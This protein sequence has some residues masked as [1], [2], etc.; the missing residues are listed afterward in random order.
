MKTDIQIAQENVMEPIERI[1]R[2]AK[3]DSEYLEHYGKYKAKIDLRIMEGLNNQKDGKLILVT[4]INPTK[5]GEGKSTTTVGLADGLARLNKMV[6]GALREPSLGPVFGVKGG[7][8]GGGMAQVVPME[9]INLHFNGDMH[10]VTTANNLIS[11]AIDNHMYHGNTLNIDP[12]HIVWKRCMDMN[13]RA[14]RQVRVAMGDKNGIERKD[15][16]NITVASEIMAILCLSSSLQDFQQRVERCVVAYNKDNKPVTVKDLSVGGAVAMIMKEAI[17]PNLVQTLEKTPILIHGGPFANIA[18]GCNSI[19]ATKMALKLADYVVTES[20]FGVDLGAEKFMDIKCQVAKIVPNAIVVVATI[21]ALKLHGG[22]AYELL[23]EENIDA[24]ANGVENMAKHLETIKK[25]RVPY[26]VAINRFV[27]DT[28]AELDWLMNWCETHGHDAVINE[29]WG[30]GSAGAEELA[31]AVIAASE[32]ES[33]FRPLVTDADS[34]EEKIERIC[35]EV[36]GANGVVYSEKAKD[37]LD[38]LTDNGWS[39]ISVCMAKNQYSLTDDQKKLGRPRD[40]QI[41]IS[42]LRISAGAG[43]V[44]AL[45][46]SVMTMPGLPKVPAANNMGIDEKGNIFGLF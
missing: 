37:Q 27:N 24:L 45:T 10:A 6:I 26:V 42:E 14:L 43:F 4:S 39:H 22:M 44:V 46:G 1:A 16:F 11:A 12:E 25:Y 21:R 30:K 15:G 2:K 18:H 17:K 8:T 9:D 38:K 28:S 33:L 29:S 32:Q 7:A 23:K 19:L 13:D 36:Y 40:F 31:K 34:V 5:A 3:I 35:K 41:H 20:G